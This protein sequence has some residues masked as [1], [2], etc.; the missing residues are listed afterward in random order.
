MGRVK[1]LHS[2]Y[3]VRPESKL[4]LFLLQKNPP[5][6]MKLMK[7]CQEIKQNWTEPENF[8]IRFCII[9]DHCY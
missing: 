7:Q 2:F 1:I 8:D 3:K 6:Q 5:S 9:F 4:S